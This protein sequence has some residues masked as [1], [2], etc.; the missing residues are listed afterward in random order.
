MW[1][2]WWT[3]R[4]WGRISPST[5]VSLANHSTNFSIIIITRGG[6]NR[7]ISGRS[8]KWTQL[9][10]TPHYTN[11]KTGTRWR[12]SGSI[13]TVRSGQGGR[14][15]PC[16]KGSSNNPSLDPQLAIP[17]SPL[18]GRLRIKEWLIK[19]HSECRAALPGVRKSKLFV[20]ESSGNCLGTYGS[21]TRKNVDK[22]Q[23]FKLNTVHAKFGQEE[24]SSYRISF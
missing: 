18:A 2:L 23:I 13:T 7:P 3:K 8:A 1:G 19:K 15:T 22:K 5:L 21:W 24:E 11:K 4:H 17:I 16:R 20:E 6:H 9:D 10:S 14:Q 12:S